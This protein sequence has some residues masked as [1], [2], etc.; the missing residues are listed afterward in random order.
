M[1]RAQMTFQTGFRLGVG[2]A[3]S[4]SAVMV[5]GKGGVEGDAQNR[6]RGADQWLFVISGTGVANINGR[7]VALGAGTMVLIERG[8]THEIRNTGRS[9]LKT[10]NVY[11]PP[12]YADA[13]TE[14]PAG[15][16]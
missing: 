16:R 14:L 9:L 7:A 12:A 11:L 13:D 5:L 10:V 3:R 2:N 4:Q 1:K 8:D 15:K 6:H